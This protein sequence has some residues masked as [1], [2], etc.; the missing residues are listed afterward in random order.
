V[1]STN[2]LNAAAVVTGLSLGVA[3]VALAAWLCGGWGVLAVVLGV[4]YLAGRA[5]AARPD[6]QTEDE[7]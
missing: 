3:A 2:C 6:A 4:C 1:N 7:R 5:L